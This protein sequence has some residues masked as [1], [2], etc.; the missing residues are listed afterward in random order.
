MSDELVLC[1]FVFSVLEHFH[2]VG[3]FNLVRLLNFH[4]RLLPVLNQEA[5]IRD[6]AGSCTVTVR[7][8]TA[9]SVQLLPLAA[10][11]ARGDARKGDLAIQL[12]PPFAKACLCQSF[13]RRKVRHRLVL[14]EQRPAMSVGQC[15]HVRVDAL[16]QWRDRTELD[17]VAAFK[18]A[19]DSTLAELVGNFLE[20]LGQPLVVKFADSRVT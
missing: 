9:V 12:G 2:L 14:H 10:Q 1:L 8:K 18:N 16:S 7:V 20:V 4:L 13:L 17:I 6:V 15:P 5:R 3:I 19:Y 11:H